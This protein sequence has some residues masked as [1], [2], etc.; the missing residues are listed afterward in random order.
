MK[1]QF[2]MSCLTKNQKQFIH[3]DLTALLEFGNE[4]DNHIF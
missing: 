3:V 2:K 1:M 4:N